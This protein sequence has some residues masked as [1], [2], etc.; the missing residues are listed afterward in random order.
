MNQG[1]GESKL[2]RPLKPGQAL[3]FSEQNYKGHERSITADVPSLGP[4]F[5]VASLKIGPITGVTLFLEENYQGLSQEL[6]AELPSFTDSRLKDQKPKS[7]KIWSAAGRPFTG[8]WAIEVTKGQYLSIRPDVNNVGVLTT[9]RTIFDRERF[10]IVDLGP[11]GPGRRFVAL[12]MSASPS[13]KPKT[14]RQQKA[15]SLTVEDLEKLTLVEEPEA[16]FRKFSLLT[17]ENRWICYSPA[18]KSFRQ[19]AVRANR[20]IFCRSIKL[21]EDETQVGEL[22]YG[23]VA[24]YENPAYWGKA[25]IFHTYYADFNSIAGLNDT[26]SSIQLGP[27]TGATIYREA[28]FKADDPNAGKQDIISSVP[29][30]QKAQVGEDQLSSIDLWQIKE[31]A[32]LGVTFECRLSQDFRGTGDQFEEYSAYRT[33]LRLPPT[34]ETVEV[35]ATDKTTIEVDDKKYDVDEDHPVTMRP[36]PIHCLVITTDAIVPS[37]GGDLQG[38]LS[39]P[40][41]KIR[42]NTMLP[43]ERIIIFPDREVHEH[44]ANLQD[45]EIWEAT[46]KDKEGN[47]SPLVNRGKVTEAAVAETQ[48][49]IKKVMS[50]VT[51]SQDTLGGWVQAISPRELQ[52]KSWA[53]DFTHRKAAPHMP[54]KRLRD[55]VAMLPVAQAPGP[56]VKFREMSQAEVQ[57]LLAM[58]NPGLAQGL[59]DD[60]GKALNDAVSFVITKVNEVVTVV[61]TVIVN[62]AE[63]AYAWVVD[64]AQKAVAI[65]QAIFGKIGVVIADVV[66]WLKYVFDWGDILQTRDHLRE[67]VRQSLNACQTLLLDAKEPVKHFFDTQKHTLI[68]KLDEAIVALGGKVDKNAAAPGVT[69]RERSNGMLDTIDWIL[70]KIMSG[71][72][73]GLALEAIGGSGSSNSMDE[74]EKNL[75]KIW[76]KTLDKGL[77]SVAVISGGVSEVITTMVKSPDKPLL[78]VAEL[79]KIFRSLAAGTIEIAEDIIL[80]LLDLVTYLMEQVTRI[81]TDNIRI[82]F[83][84]DICEWIKESG[85]LERIGQPRLLDWMGEDPGTVGFSLLDAVTLILAIPFT[86]VYKALFHRTPFENVSFLAQEHTDWMEIGLKVAGY[87]STMLNGPI[88]WALDMVPEAEAKAQKAQKAILAPFERFSLLLSCISWLPSLY[89]FNRDYGWSPG[90]TP[91]RD[92]TDETQF[93]DKTLFG[94]ETFLLGINFISVLKDFGDELKDTI[95]SICAAIGAG[96]IALL[97]WQDSKKW[98]QPDYNILTQLLPSVGMTL[99]EP[100]QLFKVS[101]IKKKLD[102]QPEVSPVVFGVVDLSASI[103]A[104]FSL[105]LMPATVSDN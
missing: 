54:S 10:H 35:W 74:G 79:L 59:F 89:A 68:E 15:L 27:L 47:S 103:A 26:V 91:S 62:T 24:L 77:G 65:V 60:I 45:G 95:T 40:G 88:C 28:Q 2:E 9:S 25:W 50:T 80:G 61:V 41:L 99:S 49:M 101:P 48:E 69:P 13:V 29:S 83:I 3:V 84:A 73:A 75:H 18:K 5:S 86:A 30:L 97:V 22:L 20:T 55:G 32:A 67:I 82:P 71:G 8:T 98:S 57:A 52:G 102:T 90:S 92:Q 56:A 85:L 33:T 53:L 44:L 16:G 17:D 94:I 11:A 14:S 23:E 72:L 31:P 37:E 96:H 66:N 81:L 38:S 19:S 76:D 6:T 39:A 12:R 51:Y 46:Y 104:A 93:Q 70:S 7:L 105:F 43:H 78:V 100:G 21:A 42:T 63:K 64:T 58:V 36:N 1:V 34:V 87:L 4:D